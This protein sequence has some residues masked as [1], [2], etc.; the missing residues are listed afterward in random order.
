MRFIYAF[1]SLEYHTTSLAQAALWS[2]LVC[3]E[4]AGLLGPELGRSDGS[5]LSTFIE[6]LD[7]TVVIPAMSLTAVFAP[8]RP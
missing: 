6:R 1:L 2:S 8:V 7:D 4:S 5:V 3:S